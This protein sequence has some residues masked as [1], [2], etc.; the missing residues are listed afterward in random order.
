MRRKSWCSRV[1]R[2]GS[3][4][5]WLHW[6][7]QPW[8]FNASWCSSLLKDFSDFQT[9]CNKLNIVELSWTKL[10]GNRRPI[11][12][13]GACREF[14]SW[15]PV[16]GE[17]TFGSHHC[18]HCRMALVFDGVRPS[19]PWW[20]FVVKNRSSANYVLIILSNIII[21]IKLIKPTNPWKCSI[22]IFVRLGNKGTVFQSFASIPT[23]SLC[24]STLLHFD[25][26]SRLFWWPC[27]TYQ[28]N[29]WEKTWGSWASTAV[30]RKMWDA[31]LMFR[32]LLGCRIQM[33]DVSTEP[34]TVKCER[35]IRCR[36][37]WES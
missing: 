19:W 34:G 27:T 5:V 28:K 3:S 16:L 17:A 21:N 37:C 8:V 18:G 36:I 29:S 15:S 7:A 10:I 33:S 9:K 2:C 31:C 22:R 35:L 32:V 4:P 26:F 23:I 11:S 1:Q 14:P 20:I 25:T 12:W 6:E 24:F 30:S 13:S